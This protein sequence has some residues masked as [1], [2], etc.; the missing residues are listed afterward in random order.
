MKS[1]VS[2][3]TG[4]PTSAAGKSQTPAENLDFGRVPS[5]A[6]QVRSAASHWS[7]LKSKFSIGSGGKVED[8]VSSYVYVGEFWEGKKQGLGVQ[9]HDD[10]RMYAGE[11][12]DGEMH[13]WGTLTRKDGSVYRGKFEKGAMCGNGAEIIISSEQD[14]GFQ[15]SDPTRLFL[16][17]EGAWANGRREGRG[18][19][20]RVRDAQAASVQG[21]VR[22]NIVR[23]NR[24]VLIPTDTVPIAESKSK[25]AS[26]E[27]EQTDAW[28]HAVLMEIKADR[29]KTMAEKL[30][31]QRAHEMLNEGA[32]EPEGVESVV[33]EGVVEEEGGAVKKEWSEEEVTEEMVKR[34][35]QI[36]E[37]QKGESEDEDRKQIKAKWDAAEAAQYDIEMAAQAL[38]K[39]REEAEER[40]RLLEIQR[41]EALARLEKAQRNMETAKATQTEAM[42]KMK[43]AKTLRAKALQ[44]KDEQRLLEMQL[45]SMKE[46]T[47]KSGQSLQV[48][49][50]K[51]QNA[52]QEFDEAELHVYEAET[53]MAACEAKCKSAE[54]SVKRLT[55][56]YELGRDQLRVQAADCLTFHQ[57]KEVFEK[58]DADQ[59]GELERDEITLALEDLGLPSSGPAVDRFI[60][61]L[62]TDCTGT[63]DWREF[64]QLARKSEESRGV[65]GILLKDAADTEKEV[66]MEM[67]RSIGRMM[68]SK[69]TLAAAQVKVKSAQMIRKERQTAAE[70]AAAKLK[71]CQLAEERAR[72]K[73]G[74]AEIRLESLSLQVV[75]LEEEAASKTR[76]AAEAAA[77][78]SLLWEEATLELAAAERGD[79]ASAAQSQDEAVRQAALA[80]ARKRAMAEL[81]ELGQDDSVQVSQA[82]DAARIAWLKDYG[83]GPPVD[84]SRTASAAGDAPLRRS[85]SRTLKKSGGSSQFGGSMLKRR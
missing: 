14:S 44:T 8:K 28:M 41:L 70:E 50:E 4:D 6:S 29:L 80:E 52:R 84:E 55:Q 18:I 2:Q 71:E 17:F 39:E 63:L 53:Q 16:S 32:D 72:T 59:S 65:D 21:L 1:Q 12:L 15:M 22:V 56:E 27:R 85:E 42:T 82:T 62:D 34:W 73:Q 11:W 66:Q 38:Q 64:Q 79:K 46:E 10:G 47:V 45:M 33:E 83:A 31:I 7:G 25:W 35:G 81:E 26:L 75:S 23:Y 61:Q 48:Q 43:E 57:V 51:E 24:G 54:R 60:Q 9:T 68:T 69:T 3:K 5:N 13:G 40:A 77:M 37:V 30:L 49:E 58:Y 76:D 19:A 36:K 20:G 74:T 78:G 67:N